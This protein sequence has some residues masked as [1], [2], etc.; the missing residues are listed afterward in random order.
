M[1]CSHDS[2]VSRCHGYRRATSE[3]KSVGTK[4]CSND[5]SYGLRCKI[6]NLCEGDSKGCLMNCS[7]DSEV[8]RCHGYRGATW[9]AKALLLND[10]QAMT[11]MVCDARL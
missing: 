3:S 2:Q 5:H 9:K 1:N 10:V 11:H 7:H 6:M 4:W 8:S